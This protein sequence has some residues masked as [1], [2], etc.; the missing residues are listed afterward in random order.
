MSQ[1]ALRLPDSLAESIKRLAE[2]N[3]V[4]MNQYVMMTLAEKVGAV[5]ATRFFA[6][7]RARA[8][9]ALAEKIWAKV[10]GGPPLTGDELPRD[11]RAKT[12]TGSRPKSAHSPRKRSAKGAAQARASD[13]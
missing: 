2:E 3:R 12:S 9:P 10:P 7:R 6:E 8:E 5:D 11:L 13:K 4:S 1:F